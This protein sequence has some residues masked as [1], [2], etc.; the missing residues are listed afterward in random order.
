MNNLMNWRHGIPTKPDVDALIK[1][2]PPETMRPG[3]SLT[4]DQVKEHIGRCDGNR[5]RTV[6]SSWCRRLFN[7]HG[8]D[9]QRQPT[10]GFYVAT[11]T[12]VIDDTPRATRYAA[13][14]VRRQQRRL[15]NAKPEN[16]KNAAIIE[17]Q[18]RLMDAVG[19]DLRKARM[20]LLP[21]T[22][23]VSAPRI[24]PPKTAKQ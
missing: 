12:Q 1:A 13:R 6:Y 16:E 2:F 9:L 24:E 15:A 10:I 8:V 23:A 19:R 11:D 18:G 7:V 17:H 22:A 3:F 5:F 20:N 14:K 21:G 4:D